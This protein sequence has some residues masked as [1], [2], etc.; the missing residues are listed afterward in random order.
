MINEYDVGINE[1]VENVEERKSYFISI[2]WNANGLCQ[3]SIEVQNLFIQSHE[4]Y[5]MFTFKTAH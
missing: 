4:I 5:I 2:N 3:L 1:T